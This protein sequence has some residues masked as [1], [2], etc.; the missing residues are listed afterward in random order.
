MSA[1]PPSLNLRTLF[2]MFVALAVLFA[3]AISRGEALA[4]VPKELDHL[5]AAQLLAKHRSF[6]GI[7]AVELKKA[8]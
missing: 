1:L 2:A 7:D 5:G 8:L 3:P 6:C 4:A